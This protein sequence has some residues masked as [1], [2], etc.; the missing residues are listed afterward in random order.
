[1]VGAEPPGVALAREPVGGKRGLLELAVEVL[2]R[3][4]NVMRFA[5]EAVDLDAV[6]LCQQLV[7]RQAVGRQV[8]RH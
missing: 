7:E 5:A 4:R 3:L 2:E 6:P 1:M 8:I